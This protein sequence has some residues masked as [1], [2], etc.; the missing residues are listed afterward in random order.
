MPDVAR[1]DRSEHSDMRL[2]RASLVRRLAL[3]GAVLTAT[4]LLLA[5]C[6]GGSSNTS[7]SAGASSAAAGA[8]GQSAN[9]Q[10]P[11]A[12]GEVAAINGTTLQVQNSQSQTAVSYTGTTTFT[13]TVTAAASALKAGLCAVARPARSDSS[14]AASGGA[15]SG[16]AAT[17]QPTQVAAAT[18]ELSQPVNGSCTGGFGDFGGAGGF[19]RA[20]GARPGGV[21]TAR[22]SGRPSSFPSGA[23]DRAG[24]FAAGATGKITSVS[25]STFTVASVRFSRPSGGEANATAGP[26]ASP[27]STTTIV[28]VT[29]GSTTTYTE[30]VSATATAVQVGSC[31]TAL[32][33][34][35]DTGAISATSIAIS[36]KQNG[37]CGSGFGNFGRGSDAG[38]DGG[39]PNA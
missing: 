12:S 38:S 11:G 13:K 31:V 24:G 29:T 16:A 30:T 28:T 6:G 10:F 35:D 20:G 18:V 2:P 23:R 26:T 34:S 9:R 22:P 36:A 21:G 17:T 5:G 39:G 27:S 32:G 33:K 37:Q 25:G 19:D 14:G 1:S 8:T 3:G 15:A 4:G 7:G